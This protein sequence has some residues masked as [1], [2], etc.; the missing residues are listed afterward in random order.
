MTGILNEFLESSIMNYMSFGEP[1]CG[2]LIIKPV[3]RLI[4][5]TKIS[6]SMIHYV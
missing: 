2:Q 4:L 5:L 6:L 3:F 1:Q